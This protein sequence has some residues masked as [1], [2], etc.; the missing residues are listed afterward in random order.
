MTTL[1][2]DTANI[3]CKAKFS[4]GFLSTS[5]GRPSGGVYGFIRQVESAKRNM[6]ADHVICCLE[7]GG[8]SARRAINSD[9]KSDRPE[10]SLFDPDHHSAVLE[11]VSASGYDYSWGD[12]CEADDVIAWYADLG[13]KREDETIIMSADHDFFACLSPQVK[14]LRDAKKQCTTAESFEREHGYSHVHYQ[15]LGALMGDNTDSIRGI[16]RVGEVTARKMFE[17]NGWDLE[18]V[19][20]NEPICEGYGKLVRMNLELIQFRSPLAMEIHNG[21]YDAE[22]L[23]KLYAHWELHS[24]LKEM[25]V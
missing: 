16:P 10:S 22:R 2:V 12:Q 9:Y 4:H 5:D 21:F 14:L 18:E 20:K 17:R 13:T 6:A 25:V 3:Y 7:N 15:K 1:L 19:L 11:W 24:L 23:Q 8:S